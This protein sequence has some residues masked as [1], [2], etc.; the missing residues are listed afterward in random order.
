[1]VASVS[2]KVPQA[3]KTF[4]LDF[5]TYYDPAFSLK[6]LSTEDYVFGALF[7][8]IC[9]S[10]RTDTGNVEVFRDRKSTRLNSSHW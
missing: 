2:H 5:E 8:I 10:V 9:V 7:D 3:M 6:K 4:S 1:M